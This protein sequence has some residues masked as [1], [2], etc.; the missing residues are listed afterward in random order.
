MIKQFSNTSAKS[1]HDAARGGMVCDITWRVFT[2]QQ[3]E[4]FRL[5]LR[6]LSRTEAA[7]EM[8]IEHCT[9]CQHLAAA[10]R[11]VKK[12]PLRETVEIH[13]ILCK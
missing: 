8:D 1:E 3:R 4:A 2:A 13:R 6:G 5:F 12:L 10:K 7:R 9:Y 11:I